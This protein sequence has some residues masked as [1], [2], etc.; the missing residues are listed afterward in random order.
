MGISDTAKE[1][2]N[3]KKLA[4]DT[5]RTP[6]VRLNAAR[7]LL[8]E[9][10]H[11]DRSQRIAKRVSKLFMTDQTAS[12]EVRKK[13][14]SLFQFC[15][16]KKVTAEDTEA[17]EIVEQPSLDQTRKI[18]EPPDPYAGMTHAEIVA[19][20]NKGW[21]VTQYNQWL[22]IDVPNKWIIYRN[23]DDLIPYGVPP[24]PRF[25]ATPGHA[26]ETFRV[27]V[28]GVPFFVEFD[29]GG[30]KW[31]WHKVSNPLYVAA[32]GGRHVNWSACRMDTIDVDGTIIK[33]S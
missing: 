11:S 26:L 2:Q 31:G 25:R 21:N 32:L 14:T 9:T 22:K 8:R 27:V 16:D 1:L 6:D 12:A 33:A 15:M 19:E 28:E 24:D 10:N 3:L 20:K 18:P 30:P 5:E 13:A 4:S 17:P 23:P 7:K 29:L